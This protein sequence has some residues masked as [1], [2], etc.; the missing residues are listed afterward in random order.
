[1]GGLQYL[2]MVGR[3]QQEAKEE[4]ARRAA[5]YIKMLARSQDMIDEVDPANTL[6]PE[7]TA[8]FPGGGVE[9]RR[10]ARNR[11]RGQSNVVDEEPRRIGRGRVL[12]GGIGAGGDPVTDSLGQMGRNRKPEPEVMAEEVAVAPTPVQVKD[13]QEFITDPSLGD[14]L[15]QL[16]TGPVRPHRS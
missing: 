4:E 16:Q 10:T 14:V 6:P 11:R 15:L 8:F 13:E 9:G 5:N 1:M 3:K 7:I 12:A 2:Q